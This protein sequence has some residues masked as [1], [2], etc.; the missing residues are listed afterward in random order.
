MTFKPAHIIWIFLSVVLFENLSAQTQ[1]PRYNFKHLTV[2]TGLAQN[3]VYHFLQDSRGYMW[4]GT[5][6]GLTLY[7]GTRAIN[8][9]ND[10]K[11]ERSIANNFITRILEEPNGQV[12]IG[13]NAGISRYNNNDNSFSNFRLLTENG[14]KENAFCVPLGFVAD[15][16]LWLLETKTKSI[17][18]FN[19]KTQIIDSVASTPA[20]D[21][22]LWY[23]SLSRTSHIWTYLSSGTIHYT[24]RNKQLIKKETFFSEE[25]KDLNEP[26]LQVVHVL[27]QNDSVVWLSTT[28][29]LIELNPHNRKY[30]LH[31]NWEAQPVKE[32]RYTAIAPNGL[33]WAATGNNGVYT[34]NLKTKKFI[35]NYRNYRLD[36]FSIGSDNIVSLYFDRVGNIWCGSYGQGVSYTNV[37]KNYFRKLLSRNDLE[38]W[39]GNNNVH[40]IGKDHRNNTWCIMNDEGG[41]WKLN[42]ETNILEYREPLLENGKQ[43]AGRFYK[44]I[45]DGDRYAWCIGQEGLF[46][47][48]LTSNRL[49]KM[50]YHFFSSDLF[51]SNWVQEIIHLND[52]SILFSTFSGVYRITSKNGNYDIQ[53]F[54][55]LN[56][57]NFRSFSALHQDEKGTIYIKDGSDS[58]YVLQN[59]NDS[60]N[61]RVIHSISFRPEI[62]QFYTDTASDA[63]LLG[64]NLGLYSL[65]RNDYRLKKIEFKPAVPFLSISSFM[66]TDNKFWLFGEKGLFCFDEQKNS[67]RTFTVED[68]LPANEFNL[69]AFIF[70]SGECIAGTTNGLVSFY[71]FR[72]QDKIYAPLAQ[73][74]NIY[75]NDIMKGFVPNLQETNKII[76]SHR[77]NTFSFDFAPIAFQ[78]ATECSSEYKLE[79]YDP[80]WIRSGNTR[81]TRYSKIPPGNYTFQLRVIDPTG[82]ISPYGKKLEIEI[83]KAFWQTTL[84]KLAMLLILFLVLWSMIKWYLH[85]KIRKH[86]LEFEKQQAVE[87]ERTRIATDMHDDLGAGLSR[88]NFLSETIGIKKQQHQPIEEEISKIREYSHDMIDKM[89]EIV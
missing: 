20:V 56:E 59:S 8:F 85:R 13:T 32:L 11:N 27:P 80:D 50:T 69:S 49:R 40:W 1:N 44:L 34:F 14:R 48:D 63:V 57:K 43:F 38:K 37:E 15:H 2:Q 64:T 10:D 7:D 42:A 39:D 30:I 54:S 36:P 25:N 45:F 51:G 72:L 33:L 67:A 4:I 53:P 46:R 82:K 76:L 21:G 75:V 86:R 87:K 19:T 47:Y 78:N 68:G 77:Q 3:I 55:E 9:L 26:V 58:L 29:G 28:Q 81:Y 18:T 5:R 70:S 66:K 79:S 83:G 65:D 41:L 17:K 62:N 22:N 24:F 84:F 31:K 71:P 16:E 61:Y 12:W 73:L 52:H 89:G 35:E 6:N 60:K 74:T 88:I 23:D